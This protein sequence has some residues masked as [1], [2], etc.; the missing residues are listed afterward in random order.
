MELLRARNQISTDQPRHL[1]ALRE[2]L[3]GVELGDDLGNK[4]RETTWRQLLPSLSLSERENDAYLLADF[5][6]NRGE[7]PFVVI[8]PELPVDGGEVGDVRTGEHPHGDVYHLEI[9]RSG[10]RGDVTRFRADVVEDGAVEP[11][12]AEVGALRDGL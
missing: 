12:D 2:Q 1:L 3:R 10:E 4:E 11:R 7:H 5:I 9:P 6:H 8:R